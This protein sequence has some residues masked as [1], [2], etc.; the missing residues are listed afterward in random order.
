MINKIDVLTS[1]VKTIAEEVV[2][3]I[4]VIKAAILAIIEPTILLLLLKA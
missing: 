4:N 2:L 3:A 1:C